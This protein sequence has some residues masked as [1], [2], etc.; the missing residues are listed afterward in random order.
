M[1]TWTQARRYAAWRAQ[2]EALPWRLPA[3]LEW[4]KAA[5]GVDGRFFP[6]GDHLDPSFCCM[7]RSHLGRPLPALVSD[8]PFD[9]SPYG[10]RGLAGN[11]RDWCL[12][13]VSA[14][15]QSLQEPVTDERVVI[16]T[17]PE[18]TPEGRLRRHP[19]RL[20]DGDGAQHPL[21]GAQ[22]DP[23]GGHRGLH[24]VPPRAILSAAEPCLIGV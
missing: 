10:V 9:E 1:V 21:R 12:D 18:L 17:I 20:V 15:G 3:E 5:R 14:E 11:M 24:R 4:E 13:L 19:R 16:P 22:H 7:L 2:R 8:F 6:W 23:S